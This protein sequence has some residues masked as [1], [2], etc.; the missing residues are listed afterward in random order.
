MVSSL[1]GVED[2]LVMIADERNRLF[3]LAYTFEARSKPVEEMLRSMRDVAHDNPQLIPI[4]N[5][6]TAGLPKEP[7][8]LV[9]ME[10]VKLLEVKIDQELP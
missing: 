8:A 9:D 7:L 5:Q 10:Q 2:I 1:A 6:I 3:T 4:L